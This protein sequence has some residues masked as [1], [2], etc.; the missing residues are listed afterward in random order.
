[1]PS[2]P[3]R[4]KGI[5]HHACRNDGGKLSRDFCRPC[6]NQLLNVA[7]EELGAAHAPCHGLKVAADQHTACAGM[8]KGNLVTVMKTI[9]QCAIQFAAYDQAKDAMLNIFPRKPDA[10][11]RQ[12]LRLALATLQHPA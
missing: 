10:G 7:S 3:S 4:N 6:S 9:P 2:L 8:F 5:Q 1:M 11:L 12:V